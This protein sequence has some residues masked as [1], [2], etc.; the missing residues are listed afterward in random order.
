MIEYYAK[1]VGS[2]LKINNESKE[3]THEF[4]Q[5]GKP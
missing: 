2:V 3:K 1:G 5:M 4:L